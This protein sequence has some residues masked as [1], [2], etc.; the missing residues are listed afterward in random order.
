MPYRRRR[1]AKP[2]KSR[3]RWQKPTAANQKR[4][5]QRVARVALRNAK[6]LRSQRVWTDWFFG[7]QTDSLEV[8]KFKA[9][10]L[11]NPT[12][13]TQGMRADLNVEDANNTYLRNMTLSFSCTS[14][15]STARVD[16]TIYLV[17]LNHHASDWVP[18]NPSTSLDQLRGGLDYTYMGRGNSPL[19]NPMHFKL[20]KRRSFK[21]FPMALGE[22]TSTM[23]SGHLSHNMGFQLAQIHLQANPGGLRWVNMIEED[24]LPRNRYYLFVYPDSTDVA[25]TPGI[26]IGCNF[27]CVSS[28]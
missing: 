16:W 20:H 9:I 23:Q 25:N 28:N 27:T 5:I 10:P 14:P 11:I 6:I 18:V 26:Q 1:S 24:I 13:W 2:N 15:T 21:T 22:P 17:T 19:L 3:I 4:Q 12:A 7:V 8:S